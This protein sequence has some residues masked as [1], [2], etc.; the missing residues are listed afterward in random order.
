MYVVAHDGVVIPNSGHFVPEE[1][2][3]ALAE[4]LL[5]FL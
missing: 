1:Q 2:P 3:G 4:V 5:S